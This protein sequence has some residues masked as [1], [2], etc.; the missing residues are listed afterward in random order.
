MFLGLVFEL[1]EPPSQ[2][3]TGE[4]VPDRQRV[5]AFSLFSAALA[6]GGMGAGRL[7]AAPLG[8]WEL[9]WLFVADAATCLA[10]AL[11]IRLVLP[12]DRPAPAGIDHGDTVVRPL[13][14]RT[15]LSILATGLTGYALAR[16]LPALLASAAVG[17]LGDLLAMGR[18]YALVT[19]LAPPG[20]SGR[21][22][23]AFGTSWGIAATLAPVLGTR[24]LAR[25]GTTTLWDTMAVL[26][27]LLVVLHLRVTPKST[28]PRSAGKGRC[29]QPHFRNFD[30]AHQRVKESGRSVAEDRRG[31]PRG[32][33]DF[34]LH[35][36]DG[37]DLRVTT[38]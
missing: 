33:T 19:D 3:I 22:L 35:D 12:H 11:L 38:Q 20:G 21:Y 14:D 18:A 30:A 25:A 24:L 17:S 4:S 29:R 6:A 36:P 10:C 7:I 13:R 5:R 31:R 26:C 16:T 28:S 9:R 1:Y 15:L 23:A 2:A 8:R 34:R 27:L 32:L 37:H